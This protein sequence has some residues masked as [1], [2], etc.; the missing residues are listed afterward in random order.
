MLD[1]EG[2]PERPAVRVVI[3]NLAHKRLCESAIAIGKFGKGRGIARIP[4]VGSNSEVVL[5]RCFGA[6][7]GVLL[8]FFGQLG[9][10]VG[11]CG[12]LGGADQV[13]L[14]LCC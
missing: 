2:V 8:G 11:G 10:G 7:F 9:F 13:G 3:L 14:G 1:P 5:G 4:C 6:S 12:V